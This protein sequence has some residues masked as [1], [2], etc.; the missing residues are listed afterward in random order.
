VKKNSRI[1]PNATEGTHQAEVK[2]AS[3]QKL[4][5]KAPIIIF[6]KKKLRE[7]DKKKKNEPHA[8]QISETQRL[9]AA[10]PI[11]K[12]GRGKRVTRPCGGDVE[13]KRMVHND[14]FKSFRAF[15]GD[16]KQFGTRGVRQGKVTLKKR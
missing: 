12:G 8:P 15:G 13:M 10:T 5:P 14:S 2:G 7:G 4:R 9:L 6:F 3:L 16:A 1:P 11:K